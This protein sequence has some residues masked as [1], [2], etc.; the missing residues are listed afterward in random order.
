[1]VVASGGINKLRVYIPKFLVGSR[2]AGIIISPFHTGR[3]YT[4]TIICKVVINV[5]IGC[6]LQ[7]LDGITDL[8]KKNIVNNTGSKG[9]LGGKKNIKLIGISIQNKCISPN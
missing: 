7:D 4:I 5:N 6:I 9:F 1:M 2:L 3:F 8:I